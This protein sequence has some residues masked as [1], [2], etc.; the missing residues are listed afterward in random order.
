MMYSYFI[1]F[2]DEETEVM[3]KLSNLSKVTESDNDRAMI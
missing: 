3:Q 2:I 1:H